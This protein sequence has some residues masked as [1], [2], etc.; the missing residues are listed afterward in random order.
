MFMQCPR[1]HF[2]ISRRFVSLSSRF[3]RGHL[4]KLNMTHWCNLFIYGAVTESETRPLIQKGSSHY[5]LFFWA[6]HVIL[7]Q[8][9][10]SITRISVLSLCSCLCYQNCSDRRPRRAWFSFIDRIDHNL[11]FALPLLWSNHQSSLKGQRDAS[12]TLFIDLT[13]IALHGHKESLRAKYNEDANGS[14]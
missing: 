1:N 8:K 12:P 9:Y 5:A 11:H 4:F 10:R 7:R 6:R 13:F 2:L 3:D 14:D